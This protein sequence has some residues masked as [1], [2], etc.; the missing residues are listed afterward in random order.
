M[1]EIDPKLISILVGAGI[2]LL[3][4]WQY[5][6]IFRLS[7]TG[8]FFVSHFVFVLIGILATPWFIGGYL[9]ESYGDINFDLIEQGDISK[10]ILLVSAG[11][12]LVFLGNVFVD[13]IKYFMTGRRDRNSGGS[14]L[15]SGKPVDLRIKRDVSATRLKLFFLAA[16]LL[17][18][19]LLAADWKAVIEGI[20]YSYYMLDVEAFYKARAEVGSAGRLYFILVF[21]A[22]PFLSIV[23]WMLFRVE[24]RSGRKA[25]A[26]FMV[27]TSSLLL[28]LTFQK[29][30]LLIYLITL[31]A[32]EIMMKA[33]A[34]ALVGQIR[35]FHVYSI[36][37]LFWKRIA[38]WFVIIFLIA[39][40]F[41]FVSTNIRDFWLITM[42]IF[43]RI[44]GRLALNPIFYVHYFPN[45]DP[46]YGLTNVGVLSSILGFEKYAD[47]V[48]TDRYFTNIANDSGSGA[49]GALLDFYGAFGWPGF[50]ICCF[51]L[52]IILRLLDKWLLSMSPTIL[53]KG[54]YLFMIVFTYYLSQA[55]L[56]RSLSGYGGL[57]FLA[58][59]FL[60]KASLYPARQQATA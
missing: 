22:L 30:P 20:T 25:W 8:I 4:S 29:R 5:H 44:I 46:H 26:C 14:L 43:D 54:L 18:L 45:V 13:M 33:S 60:L 58:L 51:G 31:L 16:L 19:I 57:T 52:G 28:L 36:V 41:F 11:L 47:T 42:L 3:A 1:N 37:K 23:F 27:I 15:W 6:R 9:R 12:V 55:S 40:G 49:I 21:N 7:C 39:C 34:G 48:V 32:S 2:L 10:T 50:V 56:F 24:T 35:H 53:N 17:T 59:W 38:V